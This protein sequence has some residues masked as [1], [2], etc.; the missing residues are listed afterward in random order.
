MQTP[1]KFG[2][3]SSYGKKYALGNLF[4]ID[5]TQDSDSVNTHNSNGALQAKVK[6][7]KQEITIDD[8]AFNKAQQYLQ[9]GGKLSKIK[10]KYSF[11]KEI[12]NLMTLN[13]DHVER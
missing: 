7:K 8:D 9:A 5:D 10:E 13:I 2:S 11:N 1:Q 3:A 12:E 6:I 4:L